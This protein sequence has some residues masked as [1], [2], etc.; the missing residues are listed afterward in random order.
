M[1]ETNVG[2]RCSSRRNLTPDLC[3]LPASEVQRLP[4]PAWRWTHAG[5]NGGEGQI[6]V[7]ESRVVLT[8]LRHADSLTEQAC[9]MLQRNPGS[10]ED[11]FSAENLRLRDNSVE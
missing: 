3:C 6:E 4:R 9:D 5:V 10:L 11:V 1:R 8:N 7:T 2:D